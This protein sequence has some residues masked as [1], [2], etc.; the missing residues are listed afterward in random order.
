[1]WYQISNAWQRKWFYKRVEK[2]PQKIPEKCVSQDSL[3]EQLERTKTLQT[4]SEKA[5]GSHSTGKKRSA[6]V[7]RLQRQENAVLN[8]FMSD[9]LKPGANEYISRKKNCGSPKLI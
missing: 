1:M 6:T 7:Q 4:D 8:N 2:F 9:A 3:T 5:R